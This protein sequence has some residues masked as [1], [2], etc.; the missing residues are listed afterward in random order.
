MLAFES[1]SQFLKQFTRQQQL[2]LVEQYSMLSRHC[3][4]GKGTSL[5]A[6]VHHEQALEAV[7]PSTVVEHKESTDER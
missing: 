2:N 7:E 1:E 5:Q 6:L 3:M 4:L